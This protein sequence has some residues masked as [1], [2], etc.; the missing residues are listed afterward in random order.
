[1]FAQEENFSYY[2]PRWDPWGKVVVFQQVRLGAAYQPEI[3]FWQS[4]M[5]V[6]DVLAEGF[7]P[8]WM[9]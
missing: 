4:G 6:P 1:M 8:R 5:K 7:S 3:A 2:G 9:P